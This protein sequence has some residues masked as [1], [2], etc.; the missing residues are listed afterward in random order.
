MDVVEVARHIGD[1]RPNLTLVTAS[2][3]LGQ[4]PPATGGGWVTS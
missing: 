2:K 3:R 1:A 4:K